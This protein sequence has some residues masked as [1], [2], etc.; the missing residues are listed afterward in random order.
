MGT[1]SCAPKIENLLG[2]ER[3]VSVRLQA[4]HNG[5]VLCFGKPKGS[6]FL[7]VELADTAFGFARQYSLA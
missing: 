6:I 2:F 5:P 7:L 4:S 1:S 3:G